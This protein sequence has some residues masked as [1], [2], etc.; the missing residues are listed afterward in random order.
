MP[1][2]TGL[3]T[4]HH[5]SMNVSFL[6]CKLGSILHQPCEGH[7]VSAGH[8]VKRILRIP[9]LDYEETEVVLFSA[10]FLLPS[11]SLAREPVLQ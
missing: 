2:V 11:S 3:V 5:P 6:F 10:V 1:K 8:S 7:R 4:E 9:S